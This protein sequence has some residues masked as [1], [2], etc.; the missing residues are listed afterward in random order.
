MFFPSWPWLCPGIRRLPVCYGYAGIRSMTGWLGVKKA[1]RRGLAAASDE[2]AD[3]AAEE[4]SETSDEPLRMPPLTMRPP[5][6]PRR[7]I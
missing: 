1:C 6:S 5:M 4:A 2:V 3:D 7:R